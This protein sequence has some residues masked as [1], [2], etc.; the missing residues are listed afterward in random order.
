MY[1]RQEDYSSLIKSENLTVIQEKESYRIE[2]EAAAIEEI[3]S[4]LR[5]RY[6]TELIFKDI[7]QFKD[8]NI[9]N[10]YSTSSTYTIGEKVV[11]GNNRY[12]C[13]QDIVTPESFTLSN[14]NKIITENT[15]VIGDLIEYTEPSHIATKTYLLSDRVE[16][17]GNIY[18]C[19]TPVTIASVFDSAKWKYICEDKTLFHVLQSV[20]NKY[21]DEYIATY[22]SQ[23]YITNVD[24]ITGWNKSTVILYCKKTAIGSISFYSSDVD[25]QAG[26][27]AITSISYS[28]AGLML[29]LSVE[30]SSSST[31]SGWV[32]IT[33]FATTGTDWQIELSQAFVMGD[34]RNAKIRN[35][36]MD[37]SL[38]EL[39]KRINPRNIPELRIIAKDDAISWLTKVAKGILVVDLPLRANK[40]DGLMIESGNDIPIY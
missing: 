22:T 17:K 37:V 38:F 13:I 27:N 16:Y 3:S 28:E 11:Y 18:S 35:V 5:H 31:L 32:T 10:N 21:P 30:I 2:S 33:D 12:I 25:R 23:N 40:S 8:S 29:P 14:W 34:N 4:Y 20:T 6:A 1:L 39:H 19:I 7:V 24:N 36:T 9:P 26:Q 15:F